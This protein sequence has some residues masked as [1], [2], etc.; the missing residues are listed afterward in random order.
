MRFSAVLPLL[1]AAAVSA[2]PARVQE[3]DQIIRN[4]V[5][6]GICKPVT[7]I[8]A[9]GTTEPGAHPFFLLSTHPS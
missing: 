6:A 2:A 9:R 5:E 8:F 7:V 4:D 1:L 3:R